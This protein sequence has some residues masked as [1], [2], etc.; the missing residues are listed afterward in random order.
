MGKVMARSHLGAS[1]PCADDD[2]AALVV[3]VDLLHGVGHRAAGGPDAG[4][5]AHHHITDPLGKA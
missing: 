5:L 4:E 2:R 1:G 3:D